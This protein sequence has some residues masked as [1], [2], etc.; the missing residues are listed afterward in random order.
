MSATLPPRAVVVTRPTEYEE[1]LGRHGTRAMAAFFLKS[2]GRSIDEVEATHR[3]IR[4][5][6][7]V[8]LAAIPLTW[9]RALV[10]RA[11]LDR[12]L[13]GPD[14]VVVTVG[15]DGLV[16]NVAKYLAGQVVIGVNPSKALFDGVLARHEPEHA[17]DLMLAAS[18]GR[19]RVEERALVEARTADG[20]RIVALNE[21]FVGHRAHQSARYR[22]RFGEATERHSSSG[23]VVATG[24]GATG[25]ARSIH[26]QRRCEVPLP[27]LA[28]RSLVFF[29]R[30]AFPSVATGTA[31]VE[32]TIAPESSLWIGSEMNEGGVVFGDGI[33]EDRLDFHFGVELTVRAADEGLRLLV[34]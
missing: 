17:T 7:E 29:V 15:Q 25:W 31:V 14:D 21:I 9:R 3:S 6:V 5:A 24:T 2:R 27:A 1:I 32:G 10:V 19:G 28:S 30:E 33:E 22:L 8:V 34:G 26:R 16:A 12:F 11:D 18:R 4:G 20:Q 13:F 23:V